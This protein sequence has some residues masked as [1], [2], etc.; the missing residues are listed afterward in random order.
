MDI[1]VTGSA[2]FLGSQLVRDLIACE[3]QVYGIDI[4]KDQQSQKV[5]CAD[6]QTVASDVFAK[7]KFD[8]IIHL[9]SNVGGFLHNALQQN[10]ID[11]EMSLFDKVLKFAKRADCENIIFTSNQEVEVEVEVEISKVEEQQV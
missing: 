4:R 9:A 3:H 2:G 7:Q 5:V 10:L 1:L 8:W 6:L 11:Y